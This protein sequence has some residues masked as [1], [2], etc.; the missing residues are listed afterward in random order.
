MGTEIPDRSKLEG[1]CSLQS[2]YLVQ[3]LYTAGSTETE[4]WH[5]VG[6]VILVAW[7]RNE[8]DQPHMCCEHLCALQPETSTVCKLGE[9]GSLQF[10]LLIGRMN[11]IPSQVTNW[12]SCGDAWGQLETRSRKGYTGSH[13]PLLSHDII[14]SNLSQF[15]LYP[16]TSILLTEESKGGGTASSLSPRRVVPCPH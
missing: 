15:C 11:I 5:G 3:C 1:E 14:T 10:S 9:F 6:M 7:T 8:R 4:S 13:R 12:S 2:Q 16:P